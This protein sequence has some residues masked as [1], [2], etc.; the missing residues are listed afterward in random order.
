MPESSPPVRSAARE[1][2]LQRFCR[3]LQRVELQGHNARPVF[4]V[5][6][7]DIY[8]DTHR[9]VRAEPWWAYWILTR[10]P[11]AFFASIGPQHS[12]RNGLGLF[13]REPGMPN[14]VA[15]RACE[16][17]W[18]EQQR[19]MRLKMR[20]PLLRSGVP[21]K[22]ALRL[23]N[24]PP[25]YF[26]PTDT[27]MIPNLATVELIFTL[28]SSVVCTALVYLAVEVFRAR[29]ARKMGV[30]P[31]TEKYQLLARRAEE[32]TR[33][34]GQ[35]AA[36]MLRQGTRSAQQWWVQHRG[37]FDTGFGVVVAG[38]QLLASG[39]AQLFT[40]DQRRR[41]RVPLVAAADPAGMHDGRP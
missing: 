11:S 4:D 22:D 39:I 28:V 16:H 1:T 25:P 27:P 23:V 33:R 8:P 13:S 3:Q 40:A 35:Q 5:P 7:Q 15:L 19:D 30:P 17:M 21:V 32:Q 41:V 29:R 14:S 10:Q 26:E 36:L 9:R 18:E 20:K 37:H 12:T 6:V 34:A 38:F 2:E 31:D 24:R